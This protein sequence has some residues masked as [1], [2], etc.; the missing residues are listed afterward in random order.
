MIPNIRYLALSLL[1]ENAMMVFGNLLSRA[2]QS[3]CKF[4]MLGDNYYFVRFSFS[5]RQG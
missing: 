5:F 2:V 1:K 3:S 4:P